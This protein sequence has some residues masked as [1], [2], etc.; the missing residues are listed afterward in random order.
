MDT[1]A[2][3]PTAISSND[4]LLAIVCHISLLIGGLGYLL[5]PLVVFL[6]K[7]DD[8]PFVA[9]HAKEALNFHL[10]LLLYGVCMLP[11][12]FVFMCLIVF[13]WIPLVIAVGAATLIFAIMAS[14]RAS[15][16]GYFRYP[17]TI[18]FV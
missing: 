9:F 18:R 8:S 4:K 5:L 11:L 17:L 2:A 1:S 13:I 6:M 3:A 16:G 7:R 14:V 12:F 15:E 10:S